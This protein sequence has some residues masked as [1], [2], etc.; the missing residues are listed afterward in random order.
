MS[1]AI[2]T[3][4]TD[5]G[6]ATAVAPL[7]SG[8]VVDLRKPKPRADKPDKPDAVKSSTDGDDDELPDERRSRAPRTGLPKELQEV[9]NRE[10][11]SLRDIANAFGSDGSYRIKLTRVEPETFRDPVTKQLVKVAG[12]LKNYTTPVDEETIA[13]KHGGGKYQVQFFNKTDKGSYQFFT[14]RTIE[15]V[16]DPRLD[17]TFRNEPIVQQSTTTAPSAPATPDQNPQLVGK[18]FDILREQV[19]HAQN[20]ARGPVGPDPG[21]L[22]VVELLKSQIQAGNQTIEML[23]KEISEM[24]HQKPAEDPLKEKI[25]DNLMKDD[26]ARLQATRMQ[27]ESEL[28]QLKESHHTD[29]R[30]AQE[31]WERE[32]S[33]L[34]QMQ[35]QQVLLMTQTHEIQLQAAKGAYE[36]NMKLAEHENRRLEREN[37]ELKSDNKELR[38]KKEKGPLEMLKEAE[39]LKDALGVGDEGEKTAVDRAIEMLPGAIEAAKTYFKPPQQGQ[40]QQVAAGGEQ[41]LQPKRKVVQDDA[42]NKYVLDGNGNLR[43][44]RKKPP[45][46]P[47][48]GPNGEPPIPQIAPETIETIINYLERAFTGNQDPDV[49]AQSGR[50]MVPEEIIT[51]IR[52]HKVDGF[53]SKV[54]KLPSTSPLCSQAGRN[55]MRKVGAALVGE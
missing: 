27:F 47:Q 9:R 14:Q 8:K 35:Q 32:R 29:M 55:W 34:K 12:F 28:R 6:D 16:G 51:A 41:A 10:N 21:M 23:R 33:E 43:P 52:D 38:A 36:T 26:S 44:V 45:P 20:H 37:A 25:L 24:R 19:V 46:P 3:T 13:E 42:G 50:A 1:D 5:T 22:Q 7:D 15:V 53:L 11:A 48:P 18:A 30:I 31:R 4:V 2:E 17:D 49:V 54:A 40:P 39:Q